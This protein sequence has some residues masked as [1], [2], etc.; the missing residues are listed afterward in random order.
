MVMVNGG[1]EICVHFA[2]FIYNFYSHFFKFSDPTKKQSHRCFSWVPLNTTP[3][4][5]CDDSCITI[6]FTIFGAHCQIMVSLNNY[7]N[8]GIIIS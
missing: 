5:P 3:L 2:A 4:L 7:K 1:D 8:D 6:D